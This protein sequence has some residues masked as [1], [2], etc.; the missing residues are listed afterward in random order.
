VS[1]SDLPVSPRSEALQPVD[2]TLSTPQSFFGRI[3]NS[4]IPN[5][6]EISDIVDNQLFCDLI[7][8]QPT[9]RISQKILTEKLDQV[10]LNS[11]VDSLSATSPNISSIHRKKQLAWF[12]SNKSDK[13]SSWW[14]LPMAVNHYIKSLKLNDHQFVD[15]LLHRLLL[16]PYSNT[17]IRDDMEYRCRCRSTAVMD[18]DTLFFHSFTCASLKHQFD[19]ARHVVLKNSLRVFVK[20]VF[21]ATAQ[22]SISEHQ[23]PAIE[24]V[25]AS[26]T[27]TSDTPAVQSLRADFSCVI[28]NIRK[29]V[30]V[31][32]AN[33]L[34][35]V[36]LERASQVAQ[37]ASSAYADLK[38]DKYQRAYPPQDNP[39]ISNVVPFIVE[40]TGAIGKDGY[41]F[42]D[43]IYQHAVQS[44]IEKQIIS[45]HWNVF[46]LTITTRF[47]QINS[48]QTRES[49][50][51]IHPLT[52]TQTN[53]D[54]D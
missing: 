14:L 37:S 25:F 10:K 13:G 31:G 18:S 15:A 9:I 44:G 16:S 48:N 54:L 11:V 32:V 19:Q 40:P 46:R 28:G 30:D 29:F 8:S 20:S 22:L 38:R 12:L 39:W 34:S 49:L 53:L 7:V 36:H 24:R 2:P 50:K 51:L 26:S 33:P 47:Q 6:N 21:G 52:M 1:V 23:L 5:T 43:L 35:S 3:F 4:F 27:Q 42:Y 17:S 45:K 41:L